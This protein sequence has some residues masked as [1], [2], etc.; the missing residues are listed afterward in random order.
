MLTTRNRLGWSAAYAVLV[1]ASLS[2]APEGCAAASDIYVDKPIALANAE[3]MAAPDKARWVLASIMESAD[4]RSGL[5]AIGRS[6]HSTVQIYPVVAVPAG[7]AVPQESARNVTAACSKEPG[8]GEYSGHGIAFRANTADTGTIY[9]VNHGRGATIEIFGITGLQSARAA[10]RAAW[11]GCIDLPSGT[12]GNAV[13]VTPD[14]RIYATITPVT[15]DGMP[16]PS[17]VRYWTADAGWK[18]LAGSDVKIPTGMA[19][20]PDGR[21]IYVSSF[22]EHKIIEIIVDGPAPFRREVIVPFE[23]DNLS[24]AQDGALL[25][26]GLDGTPDEI[27]RSCHSTSDSRCAFPGFVARIDPDSFAVTCTVGLGVTTTTAVTQVGRFLWFGSS[28]APSIWRAAASLLTR[29]P[30]RIDVRAGSPRR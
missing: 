9:V 22:F 21:K 19:S 14:G 8:A 12:V 16:Q 3:D 24:W 28:R 20:T 30:N 17:D 18:V 10:P 25:V 23:P 29:C 4:V 6:S 7:G 1:A 2:L 27:K 13:T 26:G 11:Q 5:Y 15:K